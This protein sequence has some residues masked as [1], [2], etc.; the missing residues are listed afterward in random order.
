MKREI[1]PKITPKVFKKNQISIRNNV[2]LIKT[3]VIIKLIKNVYKAKMEKY[4][5]KT[6]TNFL[7]IIT[8][9]FQHI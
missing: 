2:T 3:I 4:K 7:N 1:V 8:N 9:I 5:E 6:K